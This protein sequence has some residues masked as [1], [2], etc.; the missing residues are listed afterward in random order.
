VVVSASPGTRSFRTAKSPR[1][2][3][4]DNELHLACMSGTCN[5]G[6]AAALERDQR[7][8]ALIPRPGVCLDELRDGVLADVGPSAHAYVVDLASVDELVDAAG[9]VKG[10]LTRF[11]V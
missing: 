11:S 7:G 8:V 5:T 9:R 6:L 3:R 1:L 2:P 4:R 10:A